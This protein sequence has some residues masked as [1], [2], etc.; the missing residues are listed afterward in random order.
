M[1]SGITP[2]PCVA[3]TVTQRLVLPGLHNRHSPHSAVYAGRLL[4]ARGSGFSDGQP[5]FC[6][7][8]GRLMDPQLCGWEGEDRF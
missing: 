3:R 1:P 2:L 5:S 4:P 6:P 8:R 7:K